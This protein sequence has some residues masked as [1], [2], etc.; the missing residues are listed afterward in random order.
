MTGA[1]LVVSSLG[2]PSTHDVT[3]MANKTGTV[4]RKYFTRPN[5]AA[6][7]RL[8]VPFGVR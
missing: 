5:I 2:D 1:A 4:P 3:V 7:G 8:P 6:C